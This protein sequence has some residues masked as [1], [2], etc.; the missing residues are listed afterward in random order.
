MKKA[1]LPLI[2][3][4]FTAGVALA[5]TPGSDRAD[6]PPYADGWTTGDDGGTITTFTSW[7][8]SDNNNGPGNFA[9]YFIG[10]S[11]AGGADINTNGVSFGIYA[12]PGTAFATAVREFGTSLAAGDTFSF[13]LAVNFRNGNKGFDLRDGNGNTIFNLNV[14]GDRYTVNTPGGAASRD[15]FGN[16]Y[17]SNTIFSIQLTQTDLTSGTWT[18]TR[19]G[20]LSGTES[21]TY[22][23]VG[24]SF[25]FYVTGTDNGDAANNLYFN[26]LE[27]TAIPEPST[28]SLLAVCAIFGGCFYARRQR[29]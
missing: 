29:R 27:V 6:N 18:V 4:T 11:T 21:G 3:F 8:L 19:S 25:K 15:L 17:S 12:N 5:T 2:L 23:G 9:G 7:D 13:D 10:N 20:G 22:S 16:E 14:G 24:A 26:N 1:F 28:V